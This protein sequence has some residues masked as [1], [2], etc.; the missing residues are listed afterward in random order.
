MMTTV[1]E[2]KLEAFENKAWWRMY[3]ARTGSWLIE[4]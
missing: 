1:M 3:G 4:V 2:K